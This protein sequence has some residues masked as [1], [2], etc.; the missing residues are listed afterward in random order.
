[1]RTLRPTHARS[2]GAA[3]NASAARR[4]AA[5]GRLGPT[6][7]ARPPENRIKAAPGVRDKNTIATGGGTR[8]NPAPPHNISAAPANAA[9][10]FPRGQANAAASNSA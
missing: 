9:E 3:P 10:I 7:H 4:A 8:N 5:S 6:Y 1:M 2:M